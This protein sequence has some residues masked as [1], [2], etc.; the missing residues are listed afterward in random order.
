MSAPF[1]GILAF[2][3]FGVTAAVAVLAVWAL[4]LV[5]IFLR[6]RIAELRRPEAP[7]HGRDG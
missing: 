2:L 4:I 7:A 3:Y 1:G 6:L 5:I